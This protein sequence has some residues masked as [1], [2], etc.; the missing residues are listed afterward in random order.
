MTLFCRLNNI[1]IT[2]GGK[3]KRVSAQRPKR[4]DTAESIQPRRQ[5]GHGFT[6]VVLTRTAPASANEAICGWMDE[7]VARHEGAGARNDAVTS[8]GLRKDARFPVDRPY[9]GFFH[10][11]RTALKTGLFAVGNQTGRIFL[12]GKS[13]ARLGDA[14]RGA[15]GSGWER[16]GKETPAAS[17][18]IVSDGLLSATMQGLL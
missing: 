15:A 2:D 10:R 8:G 6:V 3:A 7:L 12:A 18:Q 5:G 16:L 13:G 4:G 14:W 17:C 1:Q 9:Q 11:Q